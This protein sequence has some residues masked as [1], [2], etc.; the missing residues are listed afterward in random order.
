[1]PDGVAEFIPDD[2]RTV[3]ARYGR[4]VHHRP[5]VPK[6]PKKLCPDCALS[7]AEDAKQ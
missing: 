1:M 4:R 3:C 2:V 5:H 6:K 7:L